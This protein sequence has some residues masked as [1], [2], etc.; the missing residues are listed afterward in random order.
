MG[1]FQV[2]AVAGHFPDLPPTP[3]PSSSSLRIAVTPDV[4]RELAGFR[5]AA[6]A[7]LNVPPRE[8]LYAACGQP[9]APT[10]A[11]EKYCCPDHRRLVE[12]Q[13]DAVARR[14]RPEVQPRACKYC[15]GTFTPR[16]AKQDSCSSTACRKAWRL[17]W[18]AKK[19]GPVIENEAGSLT[20]D[21]PRGSTWEMPD[22][23]GALRKY[24]ICCSTQHGMQ[25]RIL[26]QPLP[27]GKKR[28]I[29]ACDFR[30]VARRIQ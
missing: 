27:C 22:S 13:R 28:T 1:V 21:I 18:Q 14:S 24:R 5:R 6:R 17:E 19:R 29:Q 20:R 11:R 25:I 23:T 15:Q 7:P 16:Q 4:V 9:F 2:T 26:L 10:D 12:L 3:P 30:K 8:C